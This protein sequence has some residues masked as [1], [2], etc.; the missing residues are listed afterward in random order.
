MTY[1]LKALSRPSVPLRKNK[2]SSCFRSSSVFLSF[3]CSSCFFLSH[4]RKAC[5]AS[6][7][8]CCL[9][10]Q[11]LLNLKKPKLL[12]EPL[13]IRPYRNTCPTHQFFIIIPISLLVLLASKPNT[14]PLNQQ[15]W[16]PFCQKIQ[17]WT[18]C[19]L[20]SFKSLTEVINK[21]RARCSDLQT[22]QSWALWQNNFAQWHIHIKHGWKNVGDRQYEWVE[23]LVSIRSLS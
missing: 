19:P 1:C 4:N 20:A 11:A 13:P 6:L 12:F 8:S 3:N 23:V 18:H 2:H 22:F 21:W 5:C 16:L 14:W 7:F 9:Q 10:K 15:H 17:H